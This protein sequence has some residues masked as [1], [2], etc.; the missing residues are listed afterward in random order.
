[1]ET[2]ENDIVQNGIITDRVYISGAMSSLPRED[3]MRR[4]MLVE[5]H[6]RELGYVNIVNPVRFWTCRFP[7][8]YR[9]VGYRLTLLADLWMLMHCQR[10]YKMPG[11]RGS[12]GASVE[13]CV[14][15]HFK[16]WKLAKS[17]SDGIDKAVIESDREAEKARR[18]AAKQ[19]DGNNAIAQ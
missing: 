14:S 13:S 5:S 3:Y 16:I 18:R 17:I 1:M 2:K 12:H 7:W 8:L 10:I 11:W 4:F 19:N 6:L 15:Y 9:L